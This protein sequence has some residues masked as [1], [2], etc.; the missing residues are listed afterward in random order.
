MHGGGARHC[1]D[2]EISRVR[3]SGEEGEKGPAMLL[4]TMQSFW[5]TCAMV[6]RGRAAEERAAEVQRRR[7]RHG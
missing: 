1:G 4:T 2:G 7:R 3:E 5:V 6:V